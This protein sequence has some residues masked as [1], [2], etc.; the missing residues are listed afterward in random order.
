MR[1]FNSKVNLVLLM[2]AAVGCASGGEGRRVYVAA[3]AGGSGDL[4]TQTRGALD[5]IKRALTAAHAKT[6]DLVRLDIYL[7][8]GEE[9]ETVRG[10]LKDQFGT[11]HAPSQLI[12]PVAELLPAGSRIQIS[13]MA[14]AAS[15]PE[16]S[17]G[18]LYLSGQSDNAIGKHEQ[19]R[20]MAELTRRSMEGLKIALNSAG[21]S[22]ADVAN[23]V[24]YVSSLRQLESL[25]K[26]YMSYFA[27]GSVPPTSYVPRA[28]SD[29]ANPWVE[30]DADA[31]LPQAAPAP[32]RNE[33]ITPEGLVP[34]RF[35]SYVVRAAPGRTVYIG[36]QVST[37]SG[38]RLAETQNIYDRI[39]ALLQEAGATFRDLVKLRVF[40]IPSGGTYEAINTVRAKLYDPSAPPAST[41]LAWDGI[42][43]PGAHLTVDAIAVVPHK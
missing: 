28:T 18:W 32:R 27:G 34:S 12:L 22:F 38:D 31:A 2:A 37:E 4:Q 8:K 7:L 25:R 39:Q 5:K 33:F 30:I 43:T 11:T 41:L 15:A 1:A 17:R 19:I 16:D 23:V 20:D 29:G 21:A 9:P 10:I 36:A 14:V 35:Y 26:V 13:A 40:L 6:A 3:Q 24:V 42:A